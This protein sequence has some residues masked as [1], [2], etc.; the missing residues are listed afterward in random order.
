MVLL[1]QRQPPQPPVQVS[2]RR[3]ALKE[4]HNPARSAAAALTRTFSDTSSESLS[5]QELT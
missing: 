4:M 1:I 3:A 5:S 2:A